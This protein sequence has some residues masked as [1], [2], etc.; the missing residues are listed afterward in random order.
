[1][2]LQHLPPYNRHNYACAARIFNNTWGHLAPEKNISYPGLIRFCVTDHSQYGCQPI[3]LGYEFP[4]L[5]GPYLHDE[6]FDKW[7]EKINT[8]DLEPTAI[9]EMHVTF[10]NY[11]FYYG[12]INLITKGMELKFI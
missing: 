1:M 3:I 6:I 5:T 2:G 8:N 10:R 9:Y 12:K 7:T 4:N 11:R